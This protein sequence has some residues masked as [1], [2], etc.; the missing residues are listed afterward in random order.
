MT[1]GGPP[2]TSPLPALALSGNVA[3]RSHRVTLC[4]HRGVNLPPRP[5]R[6]SSHHVARLRRLGGEVSVALPPSVHRCAQ[7]ATEF[8]LNQVRIRTMATKAVGRRLGSKNYSKAFRAMVVAQSNDPAC[9]IADVAQERG[10][11]IIHPTATSSSYPLRASRR[12][13]RGISQTWLLVD[14]LEH[15]SANSTV[16]MK[17]SLSGLL[18]LAS[19]RP[20]SGV[21]VASAV[22]WRQ[23]CE[24]PRRYPF[25]TAR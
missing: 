18:S 17:P 20:D 15:P 13:S 14:L 16:F 12:H 3:R 22:P 8:P 1:T 7:S 24:R 23:A 21:P 25:A 4:G 6:F 11:G 9:S 5:G 10:L 19:A 2:R